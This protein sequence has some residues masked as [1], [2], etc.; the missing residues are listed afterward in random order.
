M[1]CRNE[2]YFSRHYY[3]VPV[4]H[5]GRYREAYYSAPHRRPPM[6]LQYA[7]WANASHEHPK[8]S[9]F[10]DI[11]Y[12]RARQYAERDELKVCI[13]SVSIYK[14]QLLTCY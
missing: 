1:N 11:F 4:V 3:F 6:C 14:D 7:I 2:Y 10:H 13:S 12:Q 9:R 5:P 8:Y